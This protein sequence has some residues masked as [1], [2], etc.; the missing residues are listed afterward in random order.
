MEAV[1]L[2]I[3]VHNKVLHPPNKIGSVEWPSVVVRPALVSTDR[4]PAFWADDW[5]SA[6]PVQTES[7]IGG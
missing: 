7:R 5:T 6:E 4:P 3:Y 1:E 2:C